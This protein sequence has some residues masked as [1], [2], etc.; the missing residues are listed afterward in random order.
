[1]FQKS[2]LGGAFLVTGVCV[3][4]GMLGLPILTS[5]AGFYPSLIVFFLTWLLMMFTGFLFLEACLWFKGGVNLISM[6]EKTV[7]PWGK[8][9]CW[10]I[11]LFLFYSLTLAYVDGGAQIISYLTGI[12][13]NQGVS[14]F[15]AALAF[16]AFTPVRFIDLLNIV[17]MIGLVISYSMLFGLGSSQ[18]NFERLSTHIDWPQMLGIFPICFAAFGYQGLIPTLCSHFDYDRK[19]II[20]SIVLGTFF[21]FIIYLSW[22]FF[23]M[24]IVPYKGANGLQEAMVAGQTSIHPVSLALKKPSLVFIGNLFG[25]FAL[26][27]SFIWVALSLRDFLADGL[28]IQKNIKGRLKLVF[29]ILAPVMVV[30]YNYPAVFLIALE[31]AGGFGG[32]FILALLPIMIIYFGRAKYAKDANF[33]VFGGKKLLLCLATFVCFEI[34]LEAIKLYGKLSS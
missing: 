7:G 19:K 21:S 12:T 5:T 18:V 22:Q 9:L 20:G 14:I 10:L 30:L 3:G 25:L 29:L 16:T 4:G 24:G 11:Y 32:A 6:T 33:R 1:M 26:V 8:R 28:S 13:Y 23:V 27:T 15:A 2:L 17:L 31:Y 34:I